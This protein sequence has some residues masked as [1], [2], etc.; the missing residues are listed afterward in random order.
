LISRLSHPAVVRVC[1]ILLGFTFLVSGLAKIGDLQ[2]FSEQVHNFRIL[3][4]AAEN[5]VAMTVPWVELVA[6][7][8]MVLGTKS[9]SAALL[10][11]MLLG[12]F[13][14]AVG[15]AMARGLDFECGCFGTADG[16][17]VGWTKILMNLTMF[18]AA[19]IG[20]LRPSSG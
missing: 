5:L 20:S 2:S 4:I 16:T 12:L 8:A 19:W 9:R 6:G 7:L 13:T 14:L 10:A 18:A 3:P 15:L 11:L 17:R 1:Q